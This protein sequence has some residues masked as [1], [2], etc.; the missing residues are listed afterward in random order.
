MSLVQRQSFV[1]K[2]RNINLYFITSVISFFSILHTYLL[3]T[4]SA[5]PA[6]KNTGGHL[7]DFIDLVRQVRKPGKIHKSGR[8]QH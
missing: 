2:L 4:F 8:R 7:L 5:G 1:Q 3:S 6:H